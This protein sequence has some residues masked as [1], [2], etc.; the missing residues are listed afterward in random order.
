M[1]HDGITTAQRVTLIAQLRDDPRI[2]T[3]TL[4]A[5]VIEPVLGYPHLVFLLL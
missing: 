2:V 5:V 3:R 1:V 4:I